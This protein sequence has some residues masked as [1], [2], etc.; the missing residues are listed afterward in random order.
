MTLCSLSQDWGGASEQT[1]LALGSGPLDCSLW[2]V[3]A[4][5]S[6]PY[7][8]NEQTKKATRKI[9]ENKG[10]CVMSVSFLNVALSDL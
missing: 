6:C 1:D 4:G 7:H 9:K 8:K 3:E 2:K 5:G 10:T